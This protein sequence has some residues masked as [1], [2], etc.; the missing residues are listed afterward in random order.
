MPA[1]H[2]RRDAL[3]AGGTTLLAGLAGCIAARRDGSG[4]PVDDG[5]DWPQ[6]GHDAANAGH[7]PDATGPTTGEVAWSFDAG[8]PTG[9][10]SPLL[11]DG[12]VHAAGTG[13][14]GTVH[15]IDAAT[16]ESRRSFEPAGWPGDA[17]AYADGRLYLATWGKR[18]YA[19]DADDGS[20]E[21]D[22]DLGHRVKA[23]PTVVDGTVYVGTVG[24]GP[25][26]VDG[27][28]DEDAFEAC[29]LVALDAD[30]GEERWRYDEFG[31]KERVE[32]APAVADGTVF[33]GTGD[34]AMV[35]V[36]AATG[37]EQWR[38]SLDD[39]VYAAPAVADGSVHVA[40]HG[41]GSVQALDAATGEVRWTAG[42]GGGNLKASPAVAGGVVYALASRFVGCAGD[43]EEDRPESAGF[44]TA[45]DAATGERRWRYRT[46]PDTR[47]APAVVDG[48]VYFGR[49]AG[50]EAV[51]A[52]SGESL[53][54]VE[55]GEEQ[56]RPYVD[57]SPAVGGGRLF[58]ATS[59]GSVHAIGEE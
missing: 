17:P 15:A 24:D 32:A 31:R 14:P 21:W 53:W 16:G 20:V 2:S 42:T 10:S 26:V 40:L 8:T 3:R 28:T 6:F 47:S 29:A 52:E 48:T 13:D 59:N 35:A 22:V 50:V 25:L 45:I 27:D 43:C 30:S 11:V 37:E 12:T 7:A 41:G 1:R 34:D 5:D 58:V 4:S 9:N 51:D 33:F 39:G 57:S 56:D 19:L 49:G 44:L 46:E 36:D 55:F 38:R 54:S 23:A 18:A